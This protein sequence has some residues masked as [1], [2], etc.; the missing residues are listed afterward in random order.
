[1]MKHFTKIRKLQTTNQNLVSK[2]SGKF[3]FFFKF[4]ELSDRTIVI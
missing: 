1:M 3:D 4:D 2:H